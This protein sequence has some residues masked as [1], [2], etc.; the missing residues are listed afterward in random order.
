VFCNPLPNNEMNVEP[1]RPKF[2]EKRFVDEAVVEN[3]LVV[4]AF[5]NK[6][7]VPTKFVAKKFVV[8][9]DVPVALTK[10][11]FWRVVDPVRSRFPKFPV[12]VV[13][14]LPLPEL[15]VLLFVSI[16]FV[17]VP[18]ISKAVVP[19]PVLLTYKPVSVVP[20]PVLVRDRSLCVPAVVLLVRSPEYRFA[21]VLIE[22]S[23]MVYVALN[24]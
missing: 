2:V 9:A 7:F 3:R 23:F 11:K 20:V 1:P 8:V 4:V 10:V 12:P 18:A 19:V 24:G 22:A 14:M 17:Q 21:A 13:V 15:I 6:L 5:V 16:P